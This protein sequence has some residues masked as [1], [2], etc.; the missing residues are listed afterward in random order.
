MSFSKNISIAII[1]AGS[2]GITAC[3]N[4]RQ[5]GFENITIFEQ[6]DRV[7]GNWVYTEE[8]KHSSVYETTHIITSKAHSS[9][10]DFP[11]PDH[12]PD[13]PSHWLMAE[14]Y[15]NYARKF[16]V[17]EKVRF[18]TT[19]QHVVRTPD[20]KW[21][22]QF[23]DPQ[24]ETRHEVF[25][26]LIVA[27]GHHWNP[28]YPDYPGKF[29]G[30]FIH[31]H[32]FKNNKPYTGKRA[33]VIGAGN[34]GCDAAVE[35]CRVAKKTYISMRRGYH[36][37]PKF[38]FGQPADVIAN[39][40]QWV[41][42][43]LLDKLYDLVLRIENGDITKYGLQRPDHSVRQSHPV[44]NSEL[45]YYIR[46]GEIIPK[47]DVERFEGKT[48]FFKDGSKEEIDAIVA[49]TGFKVTFPFFDKNF[50]D[51][52]DKEV[53]LYKRIFHPDYR[54]LM[55]VGLIQASGCF[56]KL[57]DYQSKL[58][59]NYLAGNFRLPDDMN[60]H[61]DKEIETMRNW[62]TKSAR[63]LIE[64]DYFKYSKEIIRLIPANAPAWK[65]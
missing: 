27:N 64:V 61:I 25:D 17:M 31:S 30:E 50:I 6:S 35:I 59:A 56:W 9:Y 45:L 36:F 48:V 55:F 22:V 57:A 11:M 21:D 41:P 19:V 10:E 62:Y 4:L 46:H 37:I 7:G 3:K 23:T 13:Y 20:E 18:R 32:Y 34:S 51:Y 52:E 49:A 33:M 53:R 28:R 14:Y 58:L 8:V 44:S 24:G 5:C 42:D 29:E 15:E 2:S 12:Y 54:N 47:P 1:G 65:N 16:G 43:F 63:H 40:F 26:V 39:K 60:K 38:V